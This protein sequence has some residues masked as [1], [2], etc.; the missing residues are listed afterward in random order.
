MSPLQTWYRAYA[1][2]FKYGSRDLFENTVLKEEHTYRVCREIN[3][4]GESLEL[5]EEQLALAKVTAL[6]HDVGRF[7]QYARYGTFRDQVSDNHAELGLR[8]L[9]RYGVLERLETGERELIICAIRYHNRARLPEVNPPDCLLYARLLRDADKLDIYHV[10][11]EYYPRQGHKRSRTIELNLPDT[12][13]CTDAVIRGLRKQDIIVH[14]DIRNLNDFKLLQMGW[15]FDINF[16]STLHAV[17]NRRY[18]DKIAEALPNEKPF[19][20]LL[21]EFNDYIDKRIGG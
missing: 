10:F 2:T 7:E 9:E 8:I 18:L 19:A 21:E 12:P 13:G 6:F 1:S 14:T 15:I 4:I 20:G 3:S 11:T 16:I 17:R 5:S